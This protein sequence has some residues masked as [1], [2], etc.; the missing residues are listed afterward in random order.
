MSIGNLKFDLSAVR[1]SGAGRRGQ[2]HRSL[3]AVLVRHDDV[4]AGYRDVRHAA[5]WS[6]SRAADNDVDRVGVCCGAGGR[7]QRHGVRARSNR[8]A[9]YI[10]HRGDGQSGRQSFRGDLGAFVL[11][12]NHGN[13]CRACGAVC[14]IYGKSACD[15]DRHF[16]LVLHPAVGHGGDGHGVVARGQRR[17]GQRAVVGHRYA[18][19]QLAFGHGVVD[20][21]CA[22]NAVLDSHGGIACGNALREC[23]FGSGIRPAGRVDAVLV[24]LRL[25]M[26]VDEDSRVLTGKIPLQIADI[27]DAEHIAGGWL[28]LI[29]HRVNDGARFVIPSS[30]EAF[31]AGRIHVVVADAAHEVAGSIAPYL[32][33]IIR[34]I[35]HIGRAPLASHQPGNEVIVDTVIHRA[36][37]GVRTHEV[38]GGAFLNR[39]LERLCI[40]LAYGLLGNPGD[41]CGHAGR[42]LVVEYAVLGTGSD[43]LLT[44]ALGHVHA[45][46][47]AEHGIGG[48]EL[49][50]SARPYGTDYLNG[51]APP[52]VVRTSEKI[53]TADDA[54]L[55]VCDILIP[56]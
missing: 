4:G 1:A 28:H 37:V 19:G 22:G 21:L 45:Y 20:V 49:A 39:H 50:V 12:E 31:A 15:G 51:A 34:R 11:E 40:D 18:L 56:R 53:H 47:S 27:F 26:H 54:S 2:S 5:F 35:R 14:V 8:R 10:A 44:H 33:V 24:H 17:A 55:F 36:D 52:C 43:A 16:F 13:E 23:D 46:E 30:G 48:V 7:G 3:I 25:G 32:T 29:R 41:H 38:I 42:L 9:G 6:G